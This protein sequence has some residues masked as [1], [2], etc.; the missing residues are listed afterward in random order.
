MVKQQEK[1]YR[2]V[3]IYLL[4]IILIFIASAG[5]LFSDASTSE[6]KINK[7]FFRQFRSDIGEVVASPA[8]WKGKDILKFSAI[9]GTG[10]LLFT[11]DEDIQQWTREHKTSSSDDISGFITTFGDGTLL[12]ALLLTGYISGEIFK[13]EEWRKTALLGAESFII[14]AAVVGLLKFSVGR[15]RPYTGES[16]SSFN[17]FGFSSRFY[18]FPSGHAAS[19]FSVATVIA[20]HSDK[21]YVDFLV[22]SLAGLVAASRVHD[23]KHWISDV[24]IGSVIGYFIGKKISDLHRNERMNRLQVG[25]QVSPRRQSLSLCFTF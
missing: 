22:F 5:H 15:A 14:S 10:A 13:K 19:A 4:L 11:F 16:G 21:F 23:D 17:P 8:R 18:S 9:I 25:F 12:S 6:H 2:G 24:F 20:E 1:T 3:S 7:E